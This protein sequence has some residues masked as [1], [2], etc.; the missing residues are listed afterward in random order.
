MSQFSARSGNL[1]FREKRPILGDELKQKFQKFKQNRIFFHFQKMESKIFQIQ[2]ILYHLNLI[3]AKFKQ[4]Q[5]PFFG[6]SQ[7]DLTLK[8]F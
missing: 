3:W 4:N 1:F 2:I 8:F 7:V 5:R 6:S